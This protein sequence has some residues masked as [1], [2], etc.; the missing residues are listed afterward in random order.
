MILEI[1]KS[2]SYS[3]RLAGVGTTTDTTQIHSKDTVDLNIPIQRFCILAILHLR[4]LITS[5]FFTYKLQYYSILTEIDFDYI[6][7]R[8]YITL[9]R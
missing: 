8:V 6:S 1:I 4:T 2:D 7:L 5:P 9:G 3:W